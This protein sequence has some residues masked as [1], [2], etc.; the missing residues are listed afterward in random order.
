M[1]G[2][3]ASPITWKYDPGIAIRDTDA[4]VAREIRLSIPYIVQDEAAGRATRGLLVR[5][6]P[7]YRRAT[8]L[9]LSTPQRSQA[10]KAKER[11]RAEVM[12]GE[13][14]D[15]HLLQCLLRGFQLIAGN[16][17][18]RNDSHQAYQMERGMELA[19]AV[20]CILVDAANA[21]D[22]T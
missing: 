17:G 15:P 21:G 12:G 22:V 3:V 14:R 10:H 19:R 11:A 9:P 4:A 16:V 7:A 5:A 2:F 8:A 13:A 6:L 18:A 20:L 1:Q